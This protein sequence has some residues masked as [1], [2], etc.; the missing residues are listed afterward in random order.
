MLTI[1][2]PLESA[3]RC[4]STGDLA[5]LEFHLVHYASTVTI[6][7]IL[8]TLGDHPSAPSSIDEVL[9]SAAAPVLQSVLS[10]LKAAA[11]FGQ[12][13]SL[14]VIRQSLTSAAWS[15]VQLNSEQL[16]QAAC[17]GRQATAYLW[18]A[19]QGMKVCRETFS[20]WLRSCSQVGW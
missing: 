15:G 13:S 12:C 1:F 18:L 9:D 16:F 7:K 19:A 6:F 3:A 4:A 8:P 10:V 2:S 17:E 11:L 14:E 20:R 5:D